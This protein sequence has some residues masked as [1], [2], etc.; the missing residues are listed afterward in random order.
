MEHH[1]CRRWLLI[2][3]LLLVA[4][5]SV[6]TAQDVLDYLDPWAPNDSGSQYDVDED[7]DL[8]NDVVP[9]E[10]NEDKP[11]SDND[12]PTGDIAVVPQ[13][14]QGLNDEQSF[15][16]ALLSPPESKID[17]P[18]EPV[19]PALI[20][21]VYHRQEVVFNGNEEPGTVVV[22]PKAHFLY[23]VLRDGQA[24]RYG[25]GVGRAGFAWS[26]AAEIRMKRRWPRWVPPKEM[27]DRDER[28][29]KWANG[30]PGGPKNPLGARALYLFS[31]GKDTL[32]RIHGTNDP[33]S[34][35]K[36]VSSGC[37][38]MLNEDIADLFDK[39]KIGTKVIVQTS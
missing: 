21:S 10:D 36:S 34:I 31:G 1:H 12:V 4:T 35:G 5:S 26:G 11:E 27:V 30:Q 13:D 24:M 29:S 6:A 18:V 16:P 14:D 2:G 20:D 39:V 22:D 23:Y 3:S 38:R 33:K 37:V 9:Q 8:D 17:Y 28:A 7:T 32:Y 25:V 15:D 19:N